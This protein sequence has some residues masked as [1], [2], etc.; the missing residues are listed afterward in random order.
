[1]D[2]KTGL[3]YVP[4][5][6]LWCGV[7]QPMKKIVL[8]IILV[9]LL[10]ACGENISEIPPMY[11]TEIMREQSQIPFLGLEEI[12]P[13]FEGRNIVADWVYDIQIGNAEYLFFVETATGHMRLDIGLDLLLGNRIASFYIEGNYPYVDF[14]PNVTGAYAPSLVHPISEMPEDYSKLNVIEVLF[15]D[16]ESM[17][18][19]WN[20]RGITHGS[21]GDDVR[22]AFLDMGRDPSSLYVWHD[23]APEFDYA[24][25]VPNYAEAKEFIAGWDGT[26][27]YDKFEGTWGFQHLGNGYPRTIWYR[28]AIPEEAWEHGEYATCVQIIFL[29]DKDGTVARLL[30]QD[31][32]NRN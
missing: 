23:V 12:A 1:M 19:P 10:T 13:L 6:F 30:F 16:F 14:H 18:I 11:E 15:I 21:Y 26:W 24:E 3:E 27:G 8:V 5:R 7:G 17:G 25:I 9:I 31:V 2:T 29:I 20:I 4:S 22:L 32:T 28:Y